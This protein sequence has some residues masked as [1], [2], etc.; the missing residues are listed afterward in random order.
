MDGLTTRAASEA[1]PR[2]WAP[3]LTRVPY[4]V[5][6]DPAVARAEQA[7]IFQGPVWNFLCLEVEIRTTG[8]Y[9][10]TFVGEMPVVVVRGKNG[11]VHAFENRCAHRGALI[12][13]ENC[14]SAKDFTCVYHAWRYDLAGNL[15]SV[16]FRHGVNGQGGM[17]ADFDMRQHGP[18][19]LRTATF[20]GLVFG[21]LSA[22]APPLE[23]FIGDPIAARVRRVLRK[24]VEIIGTFTQ[25]L[26][27]NWKLYIENVKDTYHASLLHLFF[28]TF[29]ITRLSQGGG[30]VVS[31]DGAHHASATLAPP[32]AADTTYR[33]AGLRSD[34]ASFRLA[35]PS[36]LEIR[37]EWGDGIQLQIL[38]LFPAFVLQQ[39][40]NCLAV[41]HIV[42]RGTDA[43]DLHWTYLGFAD[44][45]PDMR[46]LRLKQCNLVGPAGF[47]SMEDGC[48]GG[49]VQRGTGTAEASESVV[50]MGGAGAESQTTRATEAAVR[51]FWKTW[52]RLMEL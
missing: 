38:S 20:C 10:T 28:T 16:A 26:P 12:C 48:V 7:R 23:E 36:L 21:T 40:H 33:D 50:E 14:G 43:M 41:R 42:P 27:N 1:L 35:D 32:Q 25:P 30:I 2:S 18:R 13:L 4:W 47:V 5:Y 17:P 51:G 34:S 31:E 15:T 45:T 11:A 3:G 29:R 24:P 37:D 52:R 39:I 44:D 9:R 19:K 22:D 8:D 6:H 46:A 49:F